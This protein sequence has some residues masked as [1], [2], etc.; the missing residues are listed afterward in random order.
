[1]ALAGLAHD[2]RT[3]LTGIVALAEL[4]NASDLPERERGWAAALKGAAEHLGRLTSSVVDIARAEAKGL[5]LRAEP[6]ALQ[7]LVASVA[8]GLTARAEAKSLQARISIARNLPSTAIGD[9]VR[10]R[11]ALE[12]L[13][14]NAVKFTEHGSIAFAATATRLPRRRLRLSFTVA[15]SGI[16]I[17]AADLKQLFRPFAQAGGDIARRF[18]GAGLGL[19]LVKHI[20]EETGGS[21]KVTSSPGR[22]STFRLT[23][24]LGEAPDARV[25]AKSGAVAPTPALRLLCVEDNPYGRVVLGTVLRE[26]GHRVTFAGGGKAAVDAVRHGRYDAVLMDV[27]LADID[28]IEATRRIRRLRG[29]AGRVP[30]VGVS[31]RTAAGDEAAAIAAGMNAYLRKPALPSALHATLAGLADFRR[32]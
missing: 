29:A 1:V 8:A 23:V 20:A 7:E 32:A 16:G 18:G 22:G 30:I 13:I 12:N 10:L 11:S 19:M 31:G 28:G 3:P 9:A 15:D 27:A 4:L 2:I 14:D 26:L 25:R 21:L 24:V 6:F 17:V 5:S